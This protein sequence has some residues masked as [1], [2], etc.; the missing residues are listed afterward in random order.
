MND[1]PR[2][3]LSSASSFALDALCPGRQ[4]L[5]NS[6]GDVPE[7]KDEDAERGTRL[8]AAWEKGDPAGL[9]TA[10]TEI[11]ER[12]ETLSKKVVSEWAATL[13]NTPVAGQRE[14]RFYLHDESGALAASGQADRH[15][16]SA[17]HGLVIDFK[18]LWC[19]LLPPAEVNW[20][21][22]LLAVLVAREYGLKTVRFAFLK[23]MFSRSDVVDYTE[24][25]LNRAE[26]SCQQVLWE[27]RQRDAQRRPGPHCRRCKA[28]TACPEAAAWV[29]LPSTQVNAIRDTRE[30]ITQKMA[31]EIVAQLSLPNCRRIWE[32]QTARRNIE[33]AVK[34]RLKGLP[35]PE[36]AELGLMLGKPS[37]NRPITDPYGALKFLVAAGIPET[38]VWNAIAMKNGELTAVVQE[39]LGKSKKAAEQWIREKL[40][41]CIT[42]FEQDPPLEKV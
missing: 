20:Q 7:P 30:G 26:W 5:L 31:I 39:C 32:T 2:L 17:T 22:R 40:A 13:P 29:M 4:P 21:A 19:R 41:R 12:G 35:A 25:D 28:A 23:A 27:Q 11:Y 1:D 8:H 34:A 6:L 24:D 10:D 37:V 15:W 16:F 14:Q 36:L 18:S 9:D 38:K 3:G 33:D 42:E